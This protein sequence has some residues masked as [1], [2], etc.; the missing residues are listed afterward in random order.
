[1]EELVASDG[2]EHVVLEDG[3][4]EVIDRMFESLASEMRFRLF[5]WF[6][7]AGYLVYG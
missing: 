1:L 5:R 4:E 2:L 7:S 6:V 3:E